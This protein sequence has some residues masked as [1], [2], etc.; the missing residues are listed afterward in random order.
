MLL[1]YYSPEEVYDLKHH[2]KQIITCNRGVI[3]YANR[4]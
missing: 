1:A 2:E 3:V 4:I